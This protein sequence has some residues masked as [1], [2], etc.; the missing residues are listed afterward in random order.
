M[1]RLPLSENIQAK[2][3]D[4]DKI[5]FG[6]FL[7]GKLKIEPPGDRVGSVGVR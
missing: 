2:S 1:K 5:F 4:P 6:E 7:A 3:A